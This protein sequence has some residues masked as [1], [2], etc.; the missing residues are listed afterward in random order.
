VARPSGPRGFNLNSNVLTRFLLTNRRVQPTLQIL[1]VAIFAWALWQSF[2]GPQDVATNFG[3]IAFFG[4]WWT[5]VMLLSLVLFGR[6]WCYVCPIGAIS[7]Y[8]QDF[9]LRRRFPTFRR[10][11]WRVVG[12]GFSVLSIAALSFTLARL[13]LYKFGVAYT[14]WKMGVYFLVFLAIAVAL[15]LVFRQR[16]FCRYFCPATG[17]MSVTTRLSPFEITQERDSHVADCMTAEFRSNYLSTERRCVACM[18]CS[19]GEPDVPIRLRARWPGAA[20]VR[21]RLLIPDEAIIALI[22]WAVFPIDH[23]LGGHVIDNLAIVQGLPG[24]L[25]GATPYYGSILATILVF[26]AVNWIAARWSGL[27]ARAAFTRF[28]F[29]YVPLGIVFQLG[30]HLVPSLVE[31]GPSLVN[32]FMS[33]LGLPLRLPAEW[34][35]AETAAAWTARWSDASLWFSVLWGGILAWFI[36]R[37]MSTSSRQ[38]LRAL[39][40]HVALMAATTYAVTI[41]MA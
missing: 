21:Q 31:S 35:S 18:N 40:P 30:V 20:A 1:S 9:G 28:A 37:D 11:K 14:P 5:P 26:A 36:A 4:I 17:V 39:V 34:G 23:V 25:A 8:L 12:V 22:I 16:V 29:A 27:D 38:A 32:G 2:V 41:L 33:G 3:A 7:Q 13:P 6:I 19:V 10:P 24:L 15:S